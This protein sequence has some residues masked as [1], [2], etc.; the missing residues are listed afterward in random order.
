M[1]F[2]MKPTSRNPWLDIPL[3][4]YE[5]HMDAPDVAQAAM[6]AD[7]LGEIVGAY[8][9][10]SLALLGAAGGNGL[11]RVDPV[12]TRRVVAV[13]LNAGYLAICRARYGERF[14]LFEPVCCD[15]SSGS[16]FKEPVELVYAGLVLEYVNV[17]A[18]LKYAPLLVTEGGRLSFVFQ[19]ADPQQGAVSRSG[20][21]SVQ[22]LES[23]HTSVDV[24]ELID[25]LLARG[26]VVEDRRDVATAAGKR[27]TLL[28]MRTRSS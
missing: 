19:D 18:F 11:E 2:A 13:E 7:R 14:A 17:D 10:V 27:F 28:T 9:P 20:V 24:P 15:L 1:T 22:A 16:P 5:R 26:M 3:A 6:L 21:R 23:V 4:D 12:V 25:R 8:A